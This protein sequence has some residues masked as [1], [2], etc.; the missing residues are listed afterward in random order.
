MMAD[1]IPSKACSTLMASLALVSKY[2]MF[3]LDWQYV[4]ARFDEI[5]RLLS[6]MSTLFPN[7]TC[8][9]VSNVRWLYEY[10]ITHKWEAFRVSWT[11]LN[12]EFVPPAIESLE[13]L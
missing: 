12:K 2:G 9:H 4:E 11:G 3:P 5:I 8:A 13:T 7:T 1:G 10:Y 6:S